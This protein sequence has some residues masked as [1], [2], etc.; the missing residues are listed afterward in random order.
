MMIDSWIAWNEQH[1]IVQYDMTFKWSGF[2]YDTLINK[3]AER[4][5]VSPSEAIPQIARTMA[6]GICD[7][8]DKYCTGENQQYQS[9]AECLD[10]LTTAIRFGR[11]YEVGRNT[12]VC[13]SDHQKMA[14]YRPSVHCPHIGPTGGGMCVDDQTYEEKVLEKYFT[15]VP[16]VS[17]S[18]SQKEA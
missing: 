15:N 8:H 6:T 12:L 1:Q 17:P 3:T 2:L 13:R 14:Q 4:L 18:L 7:V 10:F 16:F 9:S 5:G 11:E